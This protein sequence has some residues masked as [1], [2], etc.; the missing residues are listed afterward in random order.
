[1]ICDGWAAASITLPN[2]RRQILSFLLP[3]DIVSTALV[4]RPQLDYRVEA[5]TD[6]RCRA[7]DRAQ[8]RSFLLKD[9]LFD[10]LAAAWVEEKAQ[11][12]QLIVD[13]GRRGAEE[14]VARLILNLL[15]KLERRGLIERHSATFEFPLRQ[16]H[17]AD[18]TGL[19]TV[20]V[21]G[22]MTAFRDAGLIEAGGRSLTVTNLE[23]LKHA[24]SD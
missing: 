8:L 1:M 23:G 21:S 7:F 13:L 5:I 2:G 17:I 15:G 4:F 11:A 3:G 14:R 24:A 9:K 22:I 20:Y 19:T 16:H 6:V 18:A 12:E 10:T